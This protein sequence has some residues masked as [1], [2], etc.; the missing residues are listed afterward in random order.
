VLD[1]TAGRFYEVIREGSSST[2][3]FYD[4]EG[5]IRTRFNDTG[6]SGDVAEGRAILFRRSD[7][8]AEK[9]AS[10]H[11]PVVQPSHY[12]RFTIEPITF[13]NANS[14]SYNVGNVVKYV[15][16]YDAKNGI[17]D[18]EKAKR[19]IDI[20]IETIRRQERIKAGESPAE[21]WKEMI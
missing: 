3:A 15:C 5:F 2:P 21:V 17:E 12:S 9:A 8:E 6:E 18:L 14:L 11:N 20:Q 19:Y 7:K 10:N 1:V 16:R 13:I 4:D